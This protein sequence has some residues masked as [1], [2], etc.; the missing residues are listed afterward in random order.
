MKK[1]MTGAKHHQMPCQRNRFLA[2]RPR[3]SQTGH[4]DLVGELGGPLKRR[5]RSGIWRR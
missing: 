5:R 4:D 2:A 3:G 1:D